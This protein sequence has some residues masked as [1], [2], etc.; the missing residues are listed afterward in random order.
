[1]TPGPLAMNNVVPAKACPNKFGPT[2]GM[3]AT[4]S[5]EDAAVVAKE[6]IRRNSALFKR[7]A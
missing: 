2:R 5:K 1:M 4:L 3:R 7:L 6:L